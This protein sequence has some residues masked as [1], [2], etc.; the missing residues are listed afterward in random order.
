MAA[1]SF[2]ATRRRRRRALLTLTGAINDKSGM[3]LSSLNPFENMI[4]FLI[5]TIFRKIG[6]HLETAEIPYLQHI[7]RAFRGGSE[8]C[9]P[10]SAGSR[11]DLRRSCWNPWP[12]RARRRGK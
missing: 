1:P 4:K 12:S 8:G 7:V 10:Y 2:Q 5:G 3:F 9:W 11:V 6:L